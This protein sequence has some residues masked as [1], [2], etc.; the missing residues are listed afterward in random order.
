MLVRFL[1]LSWHMFFE[2]KLL[3]C[4]STSIGNSNGKCCSLQHTLLLRAALCGRLGTCTHH[5]SSSSL[6]QARG[7]NVGLV[8]A[9]ASL[10]HSSLGAIQHRRCMVALVLTCHVSAM[11]SAYI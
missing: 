8:R 3:L 5:I 10:M 2:L 7:W 11:L 9:A 1:Q 6:W 4:G